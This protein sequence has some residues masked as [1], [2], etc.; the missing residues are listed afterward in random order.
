MKALMGEIEKYRVALII[1][2]IIGL[3]AIVGMSIIIGIVVKVLNERIDYIENE[4]CR[5]KNEKKN[6]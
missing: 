4:Y 3:V 2:L 6:K 1:C 5:L